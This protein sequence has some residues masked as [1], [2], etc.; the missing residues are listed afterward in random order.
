MCPPGSLAGW[1]SCLVGLGMDSWGDG[2]GEGRCQS[3][4]THR[5]AGASCSLGDWCLEKQ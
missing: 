2:S 4:F 3:S 5:A 1:D